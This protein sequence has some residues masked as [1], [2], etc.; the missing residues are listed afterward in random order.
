ML[1]IEVHV[2]TRYSKDSI[3]CFWPLYLKC[4]ACGI[5]IIAITEHNNVDGGLRF[6][7]F[8]KK[9]GGKVSVIVGEEVFTSQGEIIGLFLKEAIPPG[10]TAKETIEQIKLQGG[11]V[12]VPH[13]FDLKRK[14]T[15][16]QESAIS[17]NR[18]DIDCIEIHNGRNISPDFSEKQYAIAQKY[19]IRPII[20]SDAHTLIETGRNYMTIQNIPLCRGDFVKEIE[21]AGFVTAKC[22]KISHKIT[23]FA[24]LLKLL[25]GGKFIEI[26]NTFICRIRKALYKGS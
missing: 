9:R 25:I 23:I 21:N 18:N 1:K 11:V 7:E 19:S 2:H 5:S 24:R 8:C 15:V 4:I 3:M 6:S 26:Y 20:G 13:P 17:E 12:C 16:L 10:L 14:K 22:I